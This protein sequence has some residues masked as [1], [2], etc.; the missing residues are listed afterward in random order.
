MALGAVTEAEGKAV[1]GRLLK[2][3]DGGGHWQALPL[4]VP[5]GGNEPW[6]WAGERLAV[7]PLDGR[8]VYFGSRRDGLWRSSDGGLAW[9]QVAPLQLPVGTAHP[10]YDRPAGVTFVAFDPGAGSLEGRTRTVYAGV[11]G[12]G[13][14]RSQD[15]GASWAR[16]AGGPGAGLV[17]QQG[18]VTAAGVLIVTYYGG[19]GGGAVWAFDRD[20]WRAITPAPGL[21]YTALALDPRQAG[22]VLVAAYP[23][24]PDGV[25]RSADGGRSWTR[26]GSSADG[27]VP[28]WPAWSFYTLTGG[29]ALD[30]FRPGRV[31]L[32]TGLGV[33]KSEAADQRPIAWSATVGGLEE[34]VT[35]DAVSTPGGAGLISAI[36]DFDG[37]RHE[38]PA[39]VPSRTH[40]NGVFSTTTALAYQAGNP[41]CLVRVGASH[42]EPWK[43]QAGYSTD[44][45]RSWLP[46]ASYALGSHP[47]ELAFGNVAVSATSP[48]NIVWQPS[49]WA[50]PYYSIDRGRSWIRIARFD[51]APYQGG[52]HTHLWNRQQALAADQV[53]GGT[54]YLYHHGPGQLLRSSDGGKSWTVANAAR[55][56]GHWS[57]AAVRA[58]PGKAGQV[59]VALGAPACGARPPGRRPSP[60]CLRSRS[61]MPSASAS[62]PAARP[63]PRSTCRA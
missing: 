61:P 9:S 7:D 17:P 56:A 33:L 28:W 36:A 24:T 26:P 39:L 12:L 58:M 40:G 62:P 23:L 55:P 6:R 52:A 2:S 37:F 3:L 4:F 63:R 48:D 59:W 51:Q 41:N 49:N 29:L 53:R 60:G 30:P 1:P 14:Y 45:G 16:L 22:R 50:V 25:F 31:W 18:G 27:L 20:G 35:F 38:L 11:A 21:D 43:T 34:T 46:F 47:G 44:N 54:F 42:H 5:M 32:T 8:L 15:G 10:A 19:A 57:D 13:V